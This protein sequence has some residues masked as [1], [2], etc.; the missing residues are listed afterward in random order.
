MGLNPDA[1]PGL[2]SDPDRLD[3]LAAYALD[4]VDP[5]EALTIDAWLATDADAVHLEQLLR[6]AG[7]EYGAASLTEIDVAPPSGLRDRV[8]AAAHGAR[9]PAPVEFADVIDVHRIELERFALLLRSL[10]P[11]QWAAPVEPPEFAG[12][13]IHD[14]AAHVAANE[15]LAVQVFGLA[16]PALPEV[17]NDNEARTRAARSRHASMTPAETVAELEAC[18][19]AVDAAARA[20]GAGELDAEISWWGMPMRLRTVLAVRSFETWTHA[21]DIRR[22]LGLTPLAPPAPSLAA[23]SQIATGWTPLMLAGAGLDAPGR[24]VELRFTGA[25]RATFQVPTGLGPDGDVPTIAP[26]TAPDAVITVDIV[27]YCRAIGDRF[28]DGP[29]RYDA[30]GDLD[31][32]RAVIDRASALATL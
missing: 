27:D 30:T 22:A 26:G 3:D 9:P 2:P 4:A 15:G 25:T 31:L 12:W 5:D 1:T 32:A 23:M 6:D 7:G 16:D 21:D 19:A 20:S 29:L 8:L 10:T 11:E 14:V 18:T 13:T 24:S 17:A 28:P